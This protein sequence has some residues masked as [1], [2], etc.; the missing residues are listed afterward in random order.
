[1]TLVELVELE[2]IG[3]IDRP[4]EERSRRPACIQRMRA[5]RPGPL[6]ASVLVSAVVAL[7]AFAMSYSALHNL[8]I[9]NFVP[10]DL[11]SNVPIAID[12]LMV[13]SVIAT[14]FFRKNSVRWWYA[15]ALFVLST[16]V[17]VAGNIEYASEIGGD[18][19]AVCIH[20]GMPLTMMFAVHLT[21]M[22]W[23]DGSSHSDIPA[24]VDESD[25]DADR[26][27]SECPETEPPAEASS[28]NKVPFEPATWPELQLADF[29][30][31]HARAPRIGDHRDLMHAVERV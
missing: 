20:A 29:G 12:G 13:G 19:V 14:A 25:I 22:L 30:L 4:T 16:L 18:G 26:I 3:S 27:T 6:H 11:A 8:A 17:S 7:K 15:T 1:M 5:F 2:T 9:R 10:P 23:N 31:N 24:K 28:S 21:L